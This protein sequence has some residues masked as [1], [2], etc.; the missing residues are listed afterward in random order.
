MIFFAIVDTILFLIKLNDLGLTDKI[1]FF[2]DL[3]D[4]GLFD[5]I[6]SPIDLSQGHHQPSCNYG[7][8]PRREKMLYSG[9]DPES[10]ITEYTLVYENKRTWVYERMGTNGAKG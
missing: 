1:L 2:I 9:T 8:V 5:K 6:L 10:Y 4:S 3:K 7:E